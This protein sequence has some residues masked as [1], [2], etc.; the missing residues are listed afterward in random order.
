LQPTLTYNLKKEFFLKSK[1]EKRIEAIG[2]LE[3]SSWFDSKA[4][5]TGSKTKEQWLK[6]KSNEVKRLKTKFKIK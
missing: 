2:R 3:G 6:H 5:R 1:T 4:K